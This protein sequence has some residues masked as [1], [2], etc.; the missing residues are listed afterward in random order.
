MNIKKDT[1]T[2]LVESG[3]TQQKLAKETGIHPTNLCDYLRGKRKPSIA[4]KLLPFIY[5]DKRPPAKASPRD[6][7]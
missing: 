4:E 1:L 5:G 7:P 6:L 2:M 3:W